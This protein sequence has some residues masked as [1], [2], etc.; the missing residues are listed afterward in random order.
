MLVS[1]WAVEQLQSLL[2]VVIR[3]EPMPLLWLV[4]AS[5]L[6]I[7]LSERLVVRLSQ[8]RLFYTI[9]FD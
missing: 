4:V 5:K 9:S 7:V 3:L 1:P 2:F 8:L 6:R